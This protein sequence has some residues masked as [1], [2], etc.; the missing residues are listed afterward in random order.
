MY[1]NSRH[2][3]YG[4][5]FGMT[6]D[7]ERGGEGMLLCYL[8]IRNQKAKTKYS[9]AFILYHHYFVINSVIF[10]IKGICLF[11][12][13]TCF[14]GKKNCTNILLFVSLLHS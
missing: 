3:A 11:H 1:Y 4:R 5:K 8:G 2:R 12:C 9:F 14:K 7:T 13:L 6:V 10:A